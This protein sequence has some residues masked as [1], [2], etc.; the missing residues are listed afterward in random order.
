MNRN[1]YIQNKSFRTF[2][3]ASVLVSV[4]TQ[5][6]TFVDGVIVSH[7][8]SPDALSVL[9]LTS[10]VMSV[11]YL[12][13]GMISMGSSILVTKELGMRNFLKVAQFFTSSILIA[14][15][16]TSAIAAVFLGISNDIAELLTKE[17]RLL[18]LLYAYLPVTFIGSVIAVAFTLMMNFVKLTGRPELVTR[19]VLISTVVN[20]LLDLLCV[21][22]LSMGISGAAWATTLSMLAASMY[23]FPFTRKNSFDAWVKPE[24]EWLFPC[25]K[26]LV[27]NGVPSAV[28]SLAMA[29]LFAVLNMLVLKTQGA[30]GMFILSVCM[31]MLMICMLLLSGASQAVT[32]IG[33]VMLGEGDTDGY[34]GFVVGILR[35]ST[36]VL[37]VISVVLIVFPE[38]L[39]RLFGAT[40]ELLGTARQPLRVFCLSF[41]PFGIIT[42]L[43]AAYLLQGHNILSSVIKILYLV[44]LI[45]FVWAT[46]RVRPQYMWGSVSVGFWVMLL[47][48]ACIA[49]CISRKQRNLHWLT[50]ISKLP[51]NPSISLSV[52]YNK[53][54]VC[55]ALLKI[56][57]F[58]DIC[59]LKKDLYYRV[60]S[61]IE[62]LTTN[63]LSMTK[64]TGKKGSFDLRVVDDGKNL[65][66]TMKDD[67]EP[68]N[69]VA[70]YNAERGCGVEDANLSLVILNN[71][72]QNLSYNYMNGIN[73]VYMNFKYAE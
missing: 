55:E 46:S 5:V 12:F 15:F 26:N 58:L 64:E 8:V 20:I 72:C 66:V 7:F 57:T 63:L 28:G 21:G 29:L 70:K 9:S 1:Q 32:G 61:C 41:L 67:G 27:I 18:P 50:L 73:C 33:G 48:T 13:S 14:V 54:S 45:P 39:A 47:I 3:I 6:D 19:A 2:F 49:F 68:F 31:Q 69:P 65:A 40:D 35:K 43:D 52:D 11:L 4:I 36:I 60:D 22:L 10:P 17:E 30:D 62:E 38:L 34:R 71:F 51:N 59:E 25:G 24:N 42:I 23:L 53:D 16:V 44:C 56:H 37:I